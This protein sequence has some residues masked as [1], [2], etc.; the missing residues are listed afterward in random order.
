M[1]TTASLNRTCLYRNHLALGARM[2]PFAG[3][4]MPI[5]YTS[6][7][8]EARAVRRRMGVFDVSHMGRIRVEGPGSAPFLHFL[9]TGDILGLRPGRARYGF[10][11]NEQGGIIDDTVTYRLERDRFLLVCNAANRPAVWS[12]LVLWGKGWRGL[13]LEDVTQQTGMVAF[14]GPLAVA[15]AD[16]LA[17]RALASPLRP[18]ACTEAEV[19]G[20]PLFLG[21]TGYTGEDGVEFVLPASGAPS[22]WDALVQRGAT[23][24]GLGARDILRLEAGLMLHG[25]DID[26]TTTPLEAGLERFVSLEKE[27]FVGRPALLRQREE[28]VK[29]RLVGFR[30]LE[31]GIPRHGYS[32]LADGRVVGQVTSGGH[33]PTLDTDIGMG[34]VAVE[35][36]GEGTRL[37]VDIRGRQLPAEVVPLPF[38]RRPR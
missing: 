34:Y 27:E 17:G 7:L 30:M 2:V 24:C 13:L 22:L 28:G 16:A 15:E 3:W 36:A 12:W 35:Y 33:S 4:E 32:I 26:P 29:R 21:R 38:Y 6:I 8:E 19:A 9:L 31:R 18:F 37:L 1:E 14:Q 11:L 25:N 10:L 20:H 5:Q 23:P